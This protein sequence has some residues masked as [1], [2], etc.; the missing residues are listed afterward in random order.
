MKKKQDN[1]IRLFNIPMISTYFVL[2]IILISIIIYILISILISKMSLLRYFP[3]KGIIELEQSHIPKINY[4]SPTEHIKHIEKTELGHAFI[5]NDIKYTIMEKIHQRGSINVFRARDSKKNT[6]IIKTYIQEDYGSPFYINDNNQVYIES[7][8]RLKTQFKNIINDCVQLVHQPFQICIKYKKK[9]DIIIGF[10]MED[11]KHNMYDYW[12]D[13]L[14]IRIYS[15][16]TG[17]CTI[18]LDLINQ[19]VN[20]VYKTSSSLS[21]MHDNK[22]PHLDI[23]PENIVDIDNSRF[24]DFGY[25]KGPITFK[26]EILS[27]HRSQYFGTS[28]FIPIELL[29]PAKWISDLKLYNTDD[30]Y[31]LLFKIDLFALGATYIDILFGIN[32]F[33]IIENEFIPSHKRTG[34]KSV[35]LKSN[36]LEHGHLTNIIDNLKYYNILFNKYDGILC[37]CTKYIKRKYPLEEKLHKTLDIISDMTHINWHKRPDNIKF[38]Q[39]IKEL[40]QIL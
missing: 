26:K 39:S 36:E 25:F 2:I 32:V 23:K 33:I 24:I 28:G 17:V 19:F 37:Q 13:N 1:L 34:T 6:Y 35:D 30:I 40:K 4:M 5:I 18:Q 10:I 27:R 29:N 9:K 38:K 8:L 31:D 14:I 15:M 22:I 11:G 21:N 7:K 12:K 16:T 3:V 20:M